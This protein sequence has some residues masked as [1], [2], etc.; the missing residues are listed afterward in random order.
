MYLK[1]IYNM[2][3]LDGK[4]EVVKNRKFTILGFDVWEILAYFI[5]Y[6]IAGFLIETS[7]AL[8]RYGV[9]ESRQSFLYG[10]FCSIY[11][12]GAVVMVLFLQYF[13]KNRFTLFAGGFLIGS[14]TEYLV[15]L[16]GELILHVKWWDYSN[17]PLN[18]NGRICFY[19]SIFW[20]VLAIFL[21]KVVHPRI[22]KLIAYIVKKFNSKAVKSAI[23]FIT[24]FMIFDCIISAYAIQLYTIRMIANNDLNVANKEIICELNNKLYDN[25]FRTKLINT[26]F[27][28]KMMVRTYPNLKA[29]QLDG[30]MVYFKDLL[31]DIK[32]YYFKFTEQD[33]NK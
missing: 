27:N 5:V 6:S 16:I 2:E 10:P 1:G 32:P 7:F 28:D 9:L 4:K 33:F 25:K 26:F 29:Q 13:Q 31:P 20:G 23:S 18:I 22:Q 8:V 19:Y 11:G 30:T 3:N 17:M 15:S 24:I 14:I 21:M 12:I